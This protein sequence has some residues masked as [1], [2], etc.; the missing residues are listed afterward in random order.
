MAVNPNSSA[1]FTSVSGGVGT[2][3]ITSSP[4]NL[5]RIIIP[6]TYVGTINLHDAPSATGTTATSQI[7]SFGLP[8]AITP[9]SIEVGVHTAKGLVYQ[10]T[11][12]PVITIV[13]E[14]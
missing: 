7:I 3:V 5:V 2:T 6:G 8:G 1:R 13:S 10:A 11:G 9:T 4:T 14:D 12:T